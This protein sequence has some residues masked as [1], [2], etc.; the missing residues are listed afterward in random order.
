MNKF[1]FDSDDKSK[2]RFI[3]KEHFHFKKGFIKITNKP[4]DKIFTDKILDVADLEISKSNKISL[5]SYTGIVKKFSRKERKIKRKLIK[6]GEFIPIDYI[7]I[8]DFGFQKPLELDKYLNQEIY[9]IYDHIS[10]KPLFKTR[11]KLDMNSYID[12]HLFPLQIRSNKRKQCCA[13]T[14]SYLK[15]YLLYIKNLDDVLF[16]KYV[17]VEFDL[18]KN[19]VHKFVDMFEPRN[20]NDE[21]NRF[22][23][24][25]Y[26]HSVFNYFQHNDCISSSL[27]ILNAC[28]KHPILP[29]IYIKCPCFLMGNANCDDTVNLQLFIL[30]FCMFHIDEE[31]KTSQYKYIKQIY[32]DFM[33]P[34]IK[35]VILMKNNCLDFTVKKKIFPNYY[36]Q[37]KKMKKVKISTL[38]FQLSTIICDCCS[39]EHICCCYKLTKKFIKKKGIRSGY[40]VVC[41][42]SN[43]LYNT[44]HNTICVKCG[45][46]MYKH[47]KNKCPPPL[48]IEKPNIEEIDSIQKALSDENIETSKCPNCENLVTKD[49]NCDKVRCGAVDGGGQQGCGTKFCFRCREDLTGLGDRYIDHLITS[50]KPDGSNTHWICKKFAIPCP[51][52]YIKQFWDGKSNKIMCGECKIEFDYNI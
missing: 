3:T 17:K 47:K 16:D 27:Y 21:Y 50:M 5:I 22:D 46:C 11:I 33:I 23:L 31:S 15:N 26:I 32:E 1:I 49:E 8:D 48:Q 44:K 35:R 2:I 4:F 28:F 6:N 13:T 45:N 42:N 36:D 10:Y 24:K 25:Y 38:H 20:I 19:V 37:S 7:E 52:C 9:K 51:T 18:R 40:S 43:K 30:M 14:F 29:I 41:P 39:R 12:N 34:I